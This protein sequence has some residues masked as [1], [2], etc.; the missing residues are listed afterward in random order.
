MG[1]RGSRDHAQVIHC[2]GRVWRS[3]RRSPF[4]LV[5]LVG[6][7]G[8]TRKKFGDVKAEAY[9]HAFFR[10]I[11]EVPIVRTRWA[12]PTVLLPLAAGFSAVTMSAPKAEADYCEYPA[13][14]YSANLALGTGAY[15]DYPTEINGSHLHCEGGGFGL[16]GGNF[17]SFSIDAFGIGGFSCTWRCPDNT[18]APAPN[19]PGAWETYMVPQPNACADHM[20]PAGPTSEP[21]RA[22]E[23]IPPA[24]N[25]DWP[26]TRHFDSET[27][28]VA[29]GEPDALEPENPNP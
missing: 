19:P 4:R 9:I 6:L 25:P 29:P 28:N 11:R 20:E 14:G 5:V 15:C 17:Q 18:P 22:D 3:P 10:K 23:G 26:G 21:V 24:E 12:A 1:P 13:V 27:A 7:R 8:S 2:A 16:G